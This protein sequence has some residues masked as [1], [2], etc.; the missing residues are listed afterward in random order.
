MRF[1]RGDE[2]DGVGFGFFR[3]ISSDRGR[4]VAAG[5]RHEA[6]CEKP[7]KNSIADCRAAA[8]DAGSFYFRTHRLRKGMK[9]CMDIQAAL[10]QRAGVGRYV[11]SCSPPWGRERRHEWRRSIST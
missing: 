8:P 1:F 11:P 6:R 5:I 2:S 10:G 9:V 3:R 4:T 7:L